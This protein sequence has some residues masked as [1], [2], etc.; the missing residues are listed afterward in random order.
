[1]RAS[2]IA[3]TSA[4]SDGV[5]S[6]KCARRHWPTAASQPAR[7]KMKVIA[8]SNPSASNRSMTSTRLGVSRRRGRRS[9]PAAFE[10]AR[11]AF[12]VAGGPGQLGIDLEL[13]CVAPLTNRSYMREPTSM[14]CQSGTGRCSST[15]TAV[16]PRTVTSHSANSSA[17]LTVADNEIKPHRL[18]QVND[19]LFPDTAAKTVGEVVH[20]VHHDEA[21]TRQRRRR[22]VQHVAQHLGRHHD[23]RR[24]TVD[25]VVAGQQ[26]DLALP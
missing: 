18:G 15:M 9:R 14:C 17:L 24:L 1:M 13:R 2:T 8:G 21:K 12:L 7:L 16:S 6:R 19:H 20:F 23:D 5:L 3:R 25:R 26:A 4:A 10:R 11:L 22:R